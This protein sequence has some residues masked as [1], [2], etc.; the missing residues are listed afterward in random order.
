MI[1]EQQWE[2]IFKF[3][4]LTEQK[5]APTPATSAI[6]ALMQ[7]APRAAAHCAPFFICI[8]RSVEGTVPISS[9]FVQTVLCSSQIHMPSTALMF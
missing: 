9:T 5:E 3:S 6:T 4:V 8:S 1:A 2:E 7:E